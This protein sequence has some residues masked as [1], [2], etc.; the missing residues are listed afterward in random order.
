MVR[1]ATSEIPLCQTLQTK[2]EV[3]SL[4]MLPMEGKKVI[5]AKETQMDLL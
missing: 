4:H 1:L 2:M 5:M 3:G